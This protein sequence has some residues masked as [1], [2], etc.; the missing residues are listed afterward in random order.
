M[1]V[2]LNERIMKKINRQASCFLLRPVHTIAC[3]NIHSFPAHPNN[4]IFCPPPP[5]KPSKPPPPPTLN[6]PNP[7]PPL[8]H[9]LQ[10]KINSRH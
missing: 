10:T 2:Y 8:L 1:L 7:P 6:L 3:L 4:P 5:S 9:H